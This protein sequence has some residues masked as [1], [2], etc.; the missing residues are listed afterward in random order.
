MSTRAKIQ[1][2]QGT[3]IVWGEVGVGA[4]DVTH[5]LSFNDFTSNTARMGAVADLGEYFEEEYYVY[6]YVHT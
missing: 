1:I 6:Y 4:P 3:S 5:Q 2:T